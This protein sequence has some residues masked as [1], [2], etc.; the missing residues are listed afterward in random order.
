MKFK[1][2][3]SADPV[4]ALETT[5][6]DFKPYPCNRAPPP[7]PPSSPITASTPAP[8]YVES[9]PCCGEAMPVSGRRRVAGHGEGE[10]CPSDDDGIVDVQVAEEV[11]CSCASSYIAASVFVSVSVIIRIV[12]G[13]VDVVLVDVELLL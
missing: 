10:V 6:L 13:V 2:L 5:A 1:G 8:V 3:T 11:F 12:D 4:H 9:A 7:S